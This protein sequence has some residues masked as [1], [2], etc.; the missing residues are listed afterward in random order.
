MQINGHELANAP[1]EIQDNKN[2]MIEAMRNKLPSLQYA[3]ENLKTNHISL[4]EEALKNNIQAIK[5]VS[6]TS[7]K[8]KYIVHVAGKLAYTSQFPLERTSSY[9]NRRFHIQNR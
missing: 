2:V 9:K 3:S 7:K 8:D 5:F 6:T 1:A 4:I